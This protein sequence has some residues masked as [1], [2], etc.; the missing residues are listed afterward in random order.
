DVEAGRHELSL[1][2]RRH[3]HPLCKRNRF[4][5]QPVTRMINDIIASIINK[6]LSTV[7]IV[8]RRGS[9]KALSGFGVLMSPGNSSV[10]G[11]CG[12]QSRELVTRK[13]KPEL[14]NLLSK[15]QA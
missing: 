13:A 2:A 7:K 4:R 14:Q 9:A 6:R 11:T 10:N 8:V 15:S 12:T 1:W 3:R 5:L